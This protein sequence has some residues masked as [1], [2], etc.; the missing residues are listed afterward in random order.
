MPHLSL[1]DWNVNYKSFKFTCGRFI[2]DETENLR[3]REI[4][5]DPNQLARVATDLVSATRCLSIEKYPCDIFNEAAIVC[6]G[7]GREVVVQIL[8]PNAGIPYFFTASKIATVD[9][10]YTI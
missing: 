4:I 1:S 5:F 3:Q 6:T 8:N 10:V 2:V 7:H 9:F